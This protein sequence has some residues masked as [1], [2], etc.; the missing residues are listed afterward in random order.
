MEGCLTVAVLHSNIVRCEELAGYG[1]LSEE[2]EDSDKLR[3]LVLRGA[4]RCSEGSFD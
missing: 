1:M 2:S 3:D 4:E